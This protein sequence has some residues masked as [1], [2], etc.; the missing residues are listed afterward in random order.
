MTPEQ[1]TEPTHT[2]ILVA[3]ETL[4]RAGF[5]I[6]VMSVLAMVLKDKKEIHEWRQLITSQ[7]ISRLP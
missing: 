3:C 1:Q 4:M 7:P 6:E 2:D 5:A